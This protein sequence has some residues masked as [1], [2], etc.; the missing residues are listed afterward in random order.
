MVSQSRRAE[1][2]RGQYNLGV[3]YYKGEGVA[4]DQVEAVKWYRKAAEQNLRHGSIQSGRL[5]RT[6]RRRGEGSGG[7][8]EVVSQSRRTKSR[9]RSIHPGRLLRALGDGVAK[10]DVEAVKWYRKAAEQNLALAQYNLAVCYAQGDG[11]AED[12]AGSGEVV[13]QSRRAQ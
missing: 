8:G 2:R 9:A 6:R 3:C 10:D 4:K 11:V 5:L 13:S 7:G 12:Q 1:L